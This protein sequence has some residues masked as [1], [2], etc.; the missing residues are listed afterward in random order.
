M[1]EAE[2]VGCGGAE[3]EE[4]PLCRRSQLRMFDSEE[5]WL[6]GRSSYWDPNYTPRTEQR[7]RRWDR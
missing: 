4:K 6:G 5:E 3:K 2:S 7:K 1:A